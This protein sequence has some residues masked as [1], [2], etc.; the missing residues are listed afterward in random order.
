MLFAQEKRKIST[1][2]QYIRQFS[3]GLKFSFSTLIAKPKM[4]KGSPT[5]SI[6]RLFYTTTCSLAAHSC[7]NKYL[8]TQEEH[9]NP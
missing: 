7:T 1:G 6:V 4:K 9:S 3:V 8:P 2:L 5:Y